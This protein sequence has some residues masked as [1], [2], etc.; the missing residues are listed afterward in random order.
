[1]RI[2]NRCLALALLVASSAAA[3]WNPPA[4]TP[5]T[6]IDRSG[7]VAVL[8]NAPWGSATQLIQVMI[9]PGPLLYGPSTGLRV[10]NTASG[11]TVTGVSEASLGANYAWY[12]HGGLTGVQGTVASSFIQTNYSNKLAVLRGGF[13]L[14]SINNPIPLGSEGSGPYRISGV[15]G[16]LDGNIANLPASGSVSAVLGIDN[17]GVN[18]TYAGYFA[19]KGHFTDKVT[20][21][22]SAFTNA[23]LQS[24]SATGT[25]LA[26]FAADRGAYLEGGRIG[27]LGIGGAHITSGPAASETFGLWGIGVNAGHTSIGVHG[28]A[29]GGQFTKGVFGSAYSASI[30]NYGVYGDLPLGGNGYAGYFNGDVYANGVYDA[31][32]ARLKENIRPMSSA[33]ASLMRLRPVTFRYSSDPALSDMHFTREELPGFIAGEVAQIL[34]AIVKH[35]IHPPKIDAR[36]EVVSAAV[37]FDALNYTALI[38]VLVKALQEQQGVIEKLQARITALEGQR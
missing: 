5:P 6:A 10:T 31:S 12:A 17:V 13:F 36:G 15:T 8:A 37:E 29:S 26:T 28:D 7:T 25:A 32:D 33:T 4:A 27:A 35:S 3:Q 22:G 1:M 23:S 19:G 38:P 16:Q 20:V 34:P 21:I 18:G 11:P 30:A 9:D 24:Y 14:A 2:R